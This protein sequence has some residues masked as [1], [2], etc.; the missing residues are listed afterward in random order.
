MSPLR[1]RRPLRGELCSKLHLPSEE[2]SAERGT[3]ECGGRESCGKSH[4]PSESSTEVLLIFE[5]C[6]KLHLSGESCIELH[7]PAEGSRTQRR[8]KAPPQVPD[9]SFPGARTDVSRCCSRG[10]VASSIRKR[11]A[12]MTA[13]GG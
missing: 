7:L 8:A 11:K 13:K 5:L 3:A 1:P 12:M 10:G 4:L 9:G 6:S 2:K